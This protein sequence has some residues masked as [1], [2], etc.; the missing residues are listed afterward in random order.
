[1]GRSNAKYLH[2]LCS[3]H[4]QQKLAFVNMYMFTQCM[5][6]GGVLPNYLH[7]F[8]DTTLGHC[9]S[10]DVTLNS[11]GH[12]LCAYLQHTHQTGWQHHM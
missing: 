3:Y 1:M 6:G 4:P 2:A 10:H 7:G 5:I 9:G 12:L 8:V 11:F